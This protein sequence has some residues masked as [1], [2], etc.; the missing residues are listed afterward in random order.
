MCYIGSEG[1]ASHVE[2]GPFGCPQ[3][4]RLTNDDPLLQLIVTANGRA[5]AADFLDFEG[6]SIQARERQ[7][8][9]SA[10]DDLLDGINIR[11]RRA[12]RRQPSR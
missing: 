1:A 4:L 9:H 11:L 12:Q 2:R 10:L 5:I 7:A 3:E 6:G 8:L